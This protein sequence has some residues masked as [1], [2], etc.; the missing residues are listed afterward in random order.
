[1]IELST[2]LNAYIDANII[3][4]MAAILWILLN[5]AIGRTMLRKAFSLKLSV[6]YGVLMS[7]LLAPVVVGMFEFARQSGVVNTSYVVS[8]SD[9]AVAQYLDGRL[10][11]APSRFES[12]LFLRETFVADILVL[13]TPLAQ[14]IVAV[15]LLGFVSVVYRSL[16]S[17]FK[18]K[19]I[20]EKSYAWRS[21]GR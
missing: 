10:D 18:I 14:A 5:A 15:L 6:A 4:L 9:F 11:M 2:V 1:M 19:R 16:R 12:L 17:V 3:L 21:I 8:I 13:G 20:V 7:V